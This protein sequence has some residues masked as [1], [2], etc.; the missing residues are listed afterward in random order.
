MW[1][2]ASD[3]GWVVG[4]S[5]V[6][7]GPL[8]H[9]NTTVLYEVWSILKRQHLLQSMILFT[10]FYSSCPVFFNCVYIFSAYTLLSITAILK[11]NLL[12][13]Y[14]SNFSTSSVWLVMVRRTRNSETTDPEM[15][16]GGEYL[17]CWCF[18]QRPLDYLY[19]GSRRVCC[20]LNI[21]R[22]QILTGPELEATGGSMVRTRTSKKTLFFFLSTTQGTWVKTQM[23]FRT[24]SFSFGHETQ[25]GGE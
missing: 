24:W 25:W 22:W 18:S 23:T 19:C 17:C 6:C 4:H 14:A 10:P 5:Y 8:L 11:E 13:H 7:Y 20:V 12:P 16:G 1:W 21:W 15:A 9:G 2:A 3:L